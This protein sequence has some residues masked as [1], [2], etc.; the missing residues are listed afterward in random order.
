MLL[1][2][3]SLPFLPQQGS[4]PDWPALLQKPHARLPVD[5]C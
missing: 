5:P 3:L 4:A 2:L 1:F